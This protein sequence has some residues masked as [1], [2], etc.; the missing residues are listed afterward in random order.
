MAGTF[1][2][3][4]KKKKKDKFTYSRSSAKHKQNKD[5]NQNKQTKKPYTYHSQTGET[6][7]KRKNL[8]SSWRK[9][10]SII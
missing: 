5:K 7:N 6:N 3:L 10:G 1:P 9:R 4:V 8:E 2:N